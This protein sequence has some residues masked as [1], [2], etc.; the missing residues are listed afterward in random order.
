MFRGL[1]SELPAN[2]RNPAP[3]NPAIF[4]SDLLVL[5]TDIRMEKG[6][7][8]MNSAPPGPVLAEESGGGGPIEAVWW[9]ESH[10]TQWRLR[11]TAWLLGPDIDG[12]GEGP[13]AVRE[14]LCWRMRKTKDNKSGTAEQE[15]SW[16]REVTGHFG[17]LSPAMRGTFRSPPPGQPIGLPIAPGLGLGQ[18]VEDL[19][20]QVARKNFRVVVIAPDE[21]DQVDL[22][23]QKRPRRWL[24]SLRGAAHKSTQSG[25]QI[26]GWEST[27][28]WP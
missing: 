12:D 21:V 1:W 6:G 15:W 4:E 7:E 14:A 19:D 16:S 9:A 23:D 18:A 28:V 3:R 10:K 24:Y 11:G 22:S 2:D 27:E 20:D 26:V 8:I 13:R 5:T 25:D 17:N